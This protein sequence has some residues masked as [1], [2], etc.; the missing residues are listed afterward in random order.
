MPT[1]PA[2]GTAPDM[3]TV[4]VSALNAGTHPKDAVQDAMRRMYAVRADTRKDDPYRAALDDAEVAALLVGITELISR[5]GRRRQLP[6][7]YEGGPPSRNDLVWLFTAT[8]TQARR[9]ARNAA[10]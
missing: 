2:T 10:R 9:G 1:Q 4:I 6:P 8:L 5:P 3:E 7:G